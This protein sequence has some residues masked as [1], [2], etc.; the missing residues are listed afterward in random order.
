MKKLIPVFSALAFLFTVAV[1]N[2]MKAFA[3]D[4]APAPTEDSKKG[5]GSGGHD[6]KKGKH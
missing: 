6:D 1:A 3:D 4:P 2:P 5:E